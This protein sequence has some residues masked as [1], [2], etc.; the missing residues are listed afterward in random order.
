MR[1]MQGR[2]SL[3]VELQQQ[4]HDLLHGEGA[5]ACAVGPGAA[6]VMAECGLQ[7]AGISDVQDGHDE[8]RPQVWELQGEE[9]WEH[10]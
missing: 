1:Y 9:S 5:E 6:A 8:I 2:T 3:P 7:Q 4:I 10:A